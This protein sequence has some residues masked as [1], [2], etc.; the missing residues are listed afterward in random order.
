MDKLQQVKLDNG[1]IATVFT[2]H[3]S[4]ELGVVDIATVKRLAML[5]PSARINEIKFDF[6]KRIEK[7]HSIKDYIELIAEEYNFHTTVNALQQYVLSDEK[8]TPDISKVAPDK[9]TAFE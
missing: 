7:A 6:I 9:S 4:K 2:T 1:M 8:V 3:P 5:L